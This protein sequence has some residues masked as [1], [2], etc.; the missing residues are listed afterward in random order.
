MFFIL[1][2]IYCPSNLIQF[3]QQNIYGISNMPLVY[4]RAV[5][6][7]LVLIWAFPAFL[8]YFFF[9][10]NKKRLILYSR[11]KFLSTW[12]KYM[13]VW[14]LFNWLLKFLQAIFTIVVITA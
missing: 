11:G 6:M 10:V 13:I 9:F 12:N 8:Q 14:T 2:G 1:V 4:I 7:S 5:S 3:A